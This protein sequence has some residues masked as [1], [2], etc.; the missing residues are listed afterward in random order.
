VARNSKLGI[1]IEVREK[2]KGKDACNHV[3][4]DGI[5]VYGL[6][7]DEISAMA[8]IRMRIF[9]VGDFKSNNGPANANRAFLSNL[10]RSEAL[11]SICLRKIPRVLEFLAKIPF[12]SAIC[13][14]NATNL[15]FLAVSAAKCLGKKIFYLMHGCG[16]YEY[17]LNNECPN[18]TELK[19]IKAYERYIFSHSDRVFCVSKKF[20]GF[21]REREPDFADKFDYSFN[22]IDADEIDRIIKRLDRKRSNTRILSVGGGVPQKNNLAVCEAIETLNREAGLDLEYI[23]IGASHGKREAFEQYDFVRY[24]EYLPHEEVIALMTSSFLF[25]QNSA[26]DSFSLSVI[27][28]ILCGCNLLLSN[29]VGTLDV[30]CSAGDDDIIFDTS[31]AREIAAKIKHILH[32]PNVAALRNGLDTEQLRDTVAS[33]HL[34]EKICDNYSG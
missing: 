24:H 34:Y 10:S 4:R 30:L 14:C 18:E 3:S 20:M 9:F 11:H 28:A 23:V 25:I 31:D 27:E 22:G 2:L 17:E 8:V 5:E 16:S 7:R 6:G 12:T 29:N 21:M 13:L 15:N 1:P 19:K 32:T 33:R 26:F